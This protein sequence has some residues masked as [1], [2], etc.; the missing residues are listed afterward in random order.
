VILDQ[1][2]SAAWAKWRRQPALVLLLPHGYEGQG[3]E[4]SSARLERYLQLAAEDNLRIANCSTAAQ[5]FHLLRLQ[6][7]LLSSDRRPLILMTPKSLLRHPRAASSLEDLTDQQ[8]QPVLDDW[9]AADRHDKVERLILCT[10]KV[11][12]DLTTTAVKNPKPVERIA[13]ARVEMLYPFP[14]EELRRVIAGYP[15]LKQVIWLQEEPRN[16]G[17]WSYMAPR[18]E[19]LL[20]DGISLSYLGRTERASTAA[21]SDE[22]HQREQREIIEAAFEGER[23]PQIETRGVQYVD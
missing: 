14:Q 20:P 2:I 21:G 3:P 10:G 16:Q 5:Y 1:F 19:E 9:G 22:D 23:R 11:A 13:V 8:F 6:A 18:L 17:A 15:H 4:H 12:V 7:S